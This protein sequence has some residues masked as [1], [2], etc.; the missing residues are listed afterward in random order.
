MRNGGRG[1]DL[2]K[3]E[4][5]IKLKGKRVGL[6]IGF[7]ISEVHLIVSL[8]T[9]V[10]CWLGNTLTWINKGSRMGQVDVTFFNNMEETLK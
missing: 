1:W 7:Y 2:T 5:Q 8:K 9:G 4:K 10:L 3:K 6:G